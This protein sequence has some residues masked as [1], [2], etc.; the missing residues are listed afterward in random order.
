MYCPKCNTVG[1]DGDHCGDCGKKT[2]FSKY[3]CPK[4]GAP[5]FVTNKFCEHCGRPI[6]DAMKREISSR[7][8]L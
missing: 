2:I 1:H 6:Q 3:F 5:N 4:C 7:V 8:K